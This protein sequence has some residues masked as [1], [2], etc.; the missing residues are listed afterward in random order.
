VNDDAALGRQTKDVK[1]ANGNPVD[2]DELSYTPH[3]VEDLVQQKFRAVQVVGGDSTGAV[4]SERGKLRIW[5]SFKVREFP[6]KITG[7]TVLIRSIPR[8]RQQKATKPSRT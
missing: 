8:S 7:H 6:L 1:D 3:P 5:G 2:P 4:L